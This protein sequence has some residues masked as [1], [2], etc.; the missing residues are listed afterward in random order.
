[1]LC[2]FLQAFI[3]DN[4]EFKRISRF[5]A[6]SAPAATAVSSAN[7]LTILDKHFCKALI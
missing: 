6:E 2:L 4:L 1:M 3:F 7:N 5:C